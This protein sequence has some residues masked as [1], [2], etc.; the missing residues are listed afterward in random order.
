MNVVGTHRWVHQDSVVF[1]AVQR[2]L[3]LPLESEERGPNFLLLYRLLPNGILELPRSYP[4]PWKIPSPPPEV[5]IQG[6][7]GTLPRTYRSKVVPRARQTPEVFSHFSEEGVV[8]LACG[9]GKTVMTLHRLVAG[10]KLPAL[11]VV[12]TETLLAQWREE[13]LTHTDIR[14]DEIGLLQG[15]TI[16]IEG[17]PITLAM[18][19]SVALKEYPEW[20]YSHFRRVVFDEVHKCGAEKLGMAV[21]KFPGERF[22]LSATWERKDG[23]HAVYLNHIGPVLYED[24][25][26]ELTPLLYMVPTGVRMAERRFG[27]M[28]AT[29][30]KAL[31]VNRLSQHEGRNRLILRYVQQ[32]LDVGRTILV[33]GERREHLQWLYDNTEEPAKGLLM[34]IKATSKKR[35]AEATAERLRVT[36]E[37]RVMYAI[38][39]VADTGFSRRDLD[40]VIILFPFS[41]PGRLRQTIG[42][43]LR[44]LHGKKTPKVLVMVDDI[45]VPKEPKRRSGVFGYQRQEEEEGPRISS[46]SSRIL[47]LEASAKALGY[48]V[49]WMRG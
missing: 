6:R 37:S 24:V 38:P 29:I 7:A 4:V 31:L 8:S 12:H 18:L 26:D 44:E 47:E 21:S 48:D 33:L 1:P 41:D 20:V 45:E 39:L 35:K 42:R 34:G 11:V 10:R 17:K 25:R 22:G 40:T 3:T 19:N 36:K 43:A 30:V 27:R 46:W 32:A 2:D 28:K 14:P 13:I 9:Y 15:S 49:R 5:R 23:L 16:D